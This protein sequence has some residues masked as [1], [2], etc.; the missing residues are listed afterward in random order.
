MAGCV[1]C[2]LRCLAIITEYLCLRKISHRNAPKYHYAQNQL[3]EKVL[4]VVRGIQVIKAFSKEDTSL[5]SFNRAVDDSKRTNSKIELQYTPFNLL[6]LLSLKLFQY[7]LCLS[8]LY[9][10]LTIQLNYRCSL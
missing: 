4:E 3:V 6:H 8:Q 2:T 10:I 1:G 7:L 9:Y 5:N